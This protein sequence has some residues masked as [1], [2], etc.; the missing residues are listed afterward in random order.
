ME[1]RVVSFVRWLVRYVGVFSKEIYIK[2]LSVESP[3]RDR[4]RVIPI[5]SLFLL[6]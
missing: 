6:F 3:L 4:E 1:K 5:V 2:K